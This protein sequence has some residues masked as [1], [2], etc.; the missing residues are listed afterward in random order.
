MLTFT[1]TSAQTSTHGLNATKTSGPSRSSCGRSSQE[2]LTV[3][4]LT[5]GVRRTLSR[6][7]RTV[8]IRGKTKRY[9]HE[10]RLGSSFIPDLP[11]LCVF[12]SD[13]ED[14]PIRKYTKVCR[15]ANFVYPTHV[16][17]RL[18]NLLLI[19]PLLDLPR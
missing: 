8:H 12:Q 15:L 18:A 16:H 17:C 19:N 7:L 6:G 11:N 13:Q 14:T 4:G 3:I 10:Y 5:T 9:V 1:P 2:H